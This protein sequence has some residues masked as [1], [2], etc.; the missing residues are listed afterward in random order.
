MRR[1]SIVFSLAMLYP[2]TFMPVKANLDNTRRVGIAS[3]HPA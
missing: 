2:A 3:V 1:V